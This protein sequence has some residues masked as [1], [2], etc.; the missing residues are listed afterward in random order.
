MEGTDPG[1]VYDKKT[2]ACYFSGQ[3]EDVPDGA[4]Q[5][6]LGRPIPEAK[7]DRSAP[8][9]LEDS[10]YQLSYASGRAARFANWVL[11]R[12]AKRKA[13]LGEPDPVSLFIRNMPFRGLA[14]T[15][16]ALGALDMANGHGFRG[17]GKALSA[18][19]SAR[20]EHR[21]RKKRLGL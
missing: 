8:L 18:F 16:F 7:W 19:V 12:M 5:A 4:F 2:L 11:G 15:R 10:F 9:T 13:R 1:A 14:D 17:F 6:L 3:V 21:R 20:L